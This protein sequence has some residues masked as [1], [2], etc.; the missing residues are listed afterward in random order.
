M[1]KMIDYRDPMINQNTVL[2]LISDWD[3]DFKGDMIMYNQIE[4]EVKEEYGSS[5]QKKIGGW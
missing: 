2:T 5:G 1:Q 4:K 3:Q